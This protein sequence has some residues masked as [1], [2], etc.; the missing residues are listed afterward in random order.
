MTFK[1]P[2]RVTHVRIVPLYVS[3][4]RVPTFAGFTSPGSFELRIF[5]GRA[6]QTDC[7]FTELC[8]ALQYEAPLSD[9]FCTHT[10]PAVVDHLVIRGRYRT[11]S[12]I[13]VG[14][15]AEDA[16]V[17]NCS[18]LWGRDLPESNE[19]PLG[20]TLANGG[21]AGAKDACDNLGELLPLGYAGECDETHLG[22]EI[23]KTICDLDTVASGGEDQFDKFRTEVL[24][25]V[26]CKFR[27]QKGAM[28]VSIH[29]GL[30][31]AMDKIVDYL[32]RGSNAPFNMLRL[33]ALASAMICSCSQLTGTFSR[34]GGVDGLWNTL[35][36]EETGLEPKFWSLFSLLVASCH[37][38]GL[39][40]LAEHAHA[41]KGGFQNLEQGLLALIM[42]KQYSVLARM[43]VQVIQRLQLYHAIRALNVSAAELAKTWKESGGL[44]WEQIN[45]I[46]ESTEHLR[47]A[48][49]QLVQSQ[50][51]L[52]LS[53]S[54]IDTREASFLGNTYI[55][56]PAPDAI[57]AQCLLKYKGLEA[58]S[59]ILAI[60][61]MTASCSS[62]QAKKADHVMEVVVG[63]CK[64]I[65]ATQH[66]DVVLAKGTKACSLMWDTLTEVA[67]H[68]ENTN[69]SLTAKKWGC[70]IACIRAADSL[71]V[72]CHG[73]S[74]DGRVGAAAQRFLLSCSELYESGGCC[75]F[76]LKHG[77][78]S[79]VD[80]MGRAE[81]LGG[82]DRHSVHFRVVAL[83]T[84]YVLLA[85]TKRIDDVK[86]ISAF[87]KLS[88]DLL[89]SEL[90][91]E[92]FN[93]SPYKVA[94]L[95]EAAAV[96][97]SMEGESTEMAGAH[98]YMDST[99]PL[100][101]SRLY[102]M[103]FALKVVVTKLRRSP[104]SASD[105]TAVDMSN[106][107][108]RLREM[109]LFVQNQTTALQNQQEEAWT[110]LGLGK[111]CFSATAMS[112]LSTLDACLEGVEA[113]LEFILSVDVR[114]E[115]NDICK[116]FVST[117]DIILFFSSFGSTAG[118][119]LLN[120]IRETYAKCLRK[121]SVSRV[122]PSPAAE[123]LGKQAEGSISF[124]VAKYLHPSELLRSIAVLNIVI[125]FERTQY[126]VFLRDRFA[127]HSDVYASGILSILSQA[128]FF[129]HPSIKVPLIE[130]CL[131]LVHLGPGFARAVVSP[132]LELLQQE[133]EIV[134]EDREEIKCLEN[135]VD[136][137]HAISR[138]ALCKC[139]LL[140]SGAITAMLGIFKQPHLS[141]S[142]I[143]SSSLPLR[144]VQT[145]HNL[146]NTNIC[147]SADS[148]LYIRA[149]EDS[150]TID[151]GTNFVSVMLDAMRA[152]SGDQAE[153]VT[154]IFAFF[155]GHIPGKVALRS[156]ASQWKTNAYW[157]GDGSQGD[158]V[159]N[160]ASALASAAR[161]LSSTMN[162]M[163]SDKQKDSVSKAVKI[164]E[165]LQN[166]GEDDEDEDPPQP[167]DLEAR[168]E[169]VFQENRHSNAFRRDELVH[170]IG[171][172]R[173]SEDCEPQERGMAKE[174]EVE[175]QNRWHAD[176]ESKESSL[177]QQMIRGSM[178]APKYG[179]QLTSEHAGVGGY[180]Q[181]MQIDSE[182]PGLV[183]NEE[184][185][186][187]YGGILEAEAKQEGGLGTIGAVDENADDLY[188][189]IEMG[190]AGPEEMK[191]QQSESFA[192]DQL[193]P[194]TI[195]E[196]LRNPEKLQP[197]LEKHPQLLAV[198]QQSLSS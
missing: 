134:C 180:Q 72:H 115:G 18:F 41:T 191:P 137:I 168:Y 16:V 184:E 126:S 179:G 53:H 117:Y 6:D 92:G 116:A 162:E 170:L 181:E 33:S 147:L 164:L 186:D 60:I 96:S 106:L 113:C 95:Q 65:E 145:I 154:E 193:T 101:L 86:L 173:F 99:A 196:L 142:A 39:E 174:S 4:T 110:G 136:V 24:S 3:D 9:S 45:G 8:P 107:F 26:S 29:K 104:V 103:V 198:L 54:S 2:V 47:D 130:L 50:K 62:Q 27:N 51:A 121:W 43:G 189:D 135:L 197:L 35:Q 129:S 56:I 36:N 42:K 61:G 155:S 194:E 139:A 68:R 192:A 146:C 49:L 114:I 152:L 112:L 166:D 98:K 22:D 132:L 71:S 67:K 12:M 52:V 21:E 82:H 149:V 74:D 165:D 87:L 38:K 93:L 120:K 161:F 172:A 15:A 5:G 17:E 111:T 153:L 133:Y 30:G 124:S 66:F 77:S 102:G 78:R 81:S 55:E 178:I 158:S 138:D 144:V 183:G 160:T 63:A 187:L 195:A 14:V 176:R 108:G 123:V 11:L 97:K 44:D 19:V 46:V 91:R 190:E 76:L 185:E 88:S 118:S 188:G 83:D 73:G 169:E 143:S 177:V 57:A 131:K 13:I 58:L 23:Q 1:C 119:G 79:L 148:P 48:L 90:C 85:A 156:G 69:L 28:G 89:T 7:R 109:L 128:V 125:P 167:T 182:A 75:S 37:Q 25:A 40:C 64:M 151:E 20:V 157:S 140:E 150:P 171:S 80:Y 10:E 100:T 59:T 141:D 175:A 122:M 70:Y 31:K 163:K 159:I 32:D 105:F 84:F 34:K 127:E 94:S